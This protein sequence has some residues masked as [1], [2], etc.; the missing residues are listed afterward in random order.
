MKNRSTYHRN[1]RKLTRNHELV[2]NAPT[3]MNCGCQTRQPG[4]GCMCQQTR[5]ASDSA[6]NATQRALMKSYG[7]ESEG[8]VGHALL[9]LQSARDGDNFNAAHSHMNAAMAHQKAASDAR[10]EGDDAAAKEHEKAANA[11]LKGK[12]LHE[13][14]VYADPTAPAQLVGRENAAGD[15]GRD[16]DELTGQGDKTWT[17]SDSHTINQEEDDYEGVDCDDL[18]DEDERKR[19]EEYQMQNNAAPLSAIQNLG[20]EDHSDFGIGVTQFIINEA[21]DQWGDVGYDGKYQD[22]WGEGEFT[23]EH[24]WDT[25]KGTAE[26][27]PNSTEMLYGDGR[28][29]VPGLTPLT[30]EERD[31]IDDEIK[32]RLHLESYSAEQEHHLPL[33][34]TNAAVASFNFRARQARRQGRAG[35]AKGYGTMVSNRA[36]ELD[37]IYGGADLHDGGLP[38]PSLKF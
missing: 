9:A 23:G 29:R 25:Q 14:T 18:E 6:T 30:P 20:Y 34:E 12:R 7:T 3:C 11:H 13:A 24:S 27:T 32:R 15:D 8:A 38:L 17:P 10:N 33:P 4:H 2:F 37:D 36:A 1:Q 5:N 19:C 35:P 28:G 16:I 21:K 31:A 22:Q 26:G